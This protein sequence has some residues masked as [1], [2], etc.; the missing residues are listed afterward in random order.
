M[1]NPVPQSSENPKEENAERIWK[2]EGWRTPRKQDP[3]NQYEESSY[4]LT[5][6]E[7]TC[8]MPGTVPLHLYYG[9]QFN[10]FMG[11]LSV[12]TSESLN[13]VPSLGLFFFC[14]FVLPN[15]SVTVFIFVLLYFVIFVKSERMNELKPAMRVNVNSG[16]I[17]KTSGRG[18][19]SFLQQCVTRYINYF[20]AGLMFRSTYP[21]YNSTSHFY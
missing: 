6:R 3:L 13:L 4:E 12:W 2:P 14:L 10:I 19:V 17:T 1:H 11:L 5:E 8:T 16:T 15:V 18:K 21:I 9:L 20:R 7:V